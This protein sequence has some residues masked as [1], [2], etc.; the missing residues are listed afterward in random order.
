MPLLSRST[1]GKL[2]LHFSKLIGRRVRHELKVVREALYRDYKIRELEN[3]TIEVE[4]TGRLVQP[5]KPVLRE[6]ASSLSVPILNGNG[7]PHNTR[8]LGSIILNK[9]L[10]NAET[11]VL[12]ACI[13]Q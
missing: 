6:I 3:G 10:P 13:G 4:E 2:D 12:D 5:T 9:L 8:S 11:P 7:N 1:S